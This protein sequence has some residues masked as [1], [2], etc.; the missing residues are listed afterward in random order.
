M[1]EILKTP[2]PC[3]V[4]FQHVTSS[5]T[6]VAIV[7][8]ITYGYGKVNPTHNYLETT[9]KNL[10]E[11]VK[12][13]LLYQNARWYNRMDYK[14]TKVSTGITLPTIYWNNK[15]KKAKGGYQYVNTRLAEFKSYATKLY[16]AMSKNGT[17]WVEPS[18][19]A[20]QI[21]QHITSV[22]KQID[23]IKKGK[24]P[25]PKTKKGKGQLPQVVI[26]E[27][28]T[29]TEI[30]GI[31]TRLQDY[32]QFKIDKYKA[33]GPLNSGITA[34]TL[35]AYLR[36]KSY[37]ET[38]TKNAQEELNL[39]TLTTD[40]VI[41][42]INF[43]INRKRE[44]GVDY[45][46]SYLA[47][48]KKEI[49]NFINKAKGDKIPVPIH[50]HEEKKY[51]KVK[52]PKKEDPYL[53]LSHL[54]KLKEKNFFALSLEEKKIIRDNFNSEISPEVLDMTRDYFLIA[55]NSAM[56]Y[57]DLKRLRNIFM[58]E[59]GKWQFDYVSE[60]TDRRIKVPIREQ[61][62]VD[63]YLQKYNKEFNLKIQ[64]QTFN[65]A[66]K[67]CSLLAGLT[68]LVNISTID[69]HT[70]K[71]KASDVPLWTLITSK[72][73]RKSY[74]SNE[75][76]EYSTPLS[77]IQLRT[78]HSSEKTLRAYIQL[79]DEEFY[80]INQKQLEQMAELQRYRNEPK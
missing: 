20:K 52:F 47:W 58:N 73:G 61:Y 74:A 51:W 64:E 66:I 22:F 75:V 30:N 37:I 80:R 28:Y 32:I 24:S 12:D 50:F 53:T 42:F 55:A 49:K 71:Q 2:R 36:L 68:E 33:E 65:E 60:K 35:K 67:A 72:T 59:D 17:V 11:N 9:G 5:A 1:D 6:T 7:A 27:F 44:D 57:S 21:K 3:K 19:L 62:I 76:K 63:M 26:P 16:N 45:S 4:T 46:F 25:L 34:P 39:L 69:I 79:T 23:R 10:P 48:M 15:K 43:Y 41:R 18:D 77:I 14:P 40:A 70:K 29:Q 13:Y 38:Y 8:F 78:G 54:K 31:P 56:R